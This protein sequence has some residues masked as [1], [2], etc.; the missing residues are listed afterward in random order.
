MRVHVLR[1]VARRVVSGALIRRVAIAAGRATLPSARFRRASV[2][3]VLLSSAAIRMYNRRFHRRDRATDVLCF[4]DGDHADVLV[5]VDRVVA[6]AREHGM[7]P[8]RELLFVVAHGVLHFAGMRDD[9]PTRRAAMH[10]AGHAALEACR[11]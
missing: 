7:T 5:S 10:R 9:T 11:V 3:V 1:R 6:Q 8:A 2:I 4:V